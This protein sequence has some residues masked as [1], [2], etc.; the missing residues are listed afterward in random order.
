[1]VYKNNILN[2]EY[3]YY[4]AGVVDTKG[5]YK[6]GKKDGYWIEKASDKKTKCYGNYLEGEREGAWFFGFSKIYGKCNGSF[7]AGKKDGVWNY[8]DY[9]GKR[10]R[11]EKWEN[12]TIIET[13]DN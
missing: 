11:K 13:T 5:N 8:Y 1:M 4:E 12:G 9:K 2:G 6:N 3:V 10:I 7:V